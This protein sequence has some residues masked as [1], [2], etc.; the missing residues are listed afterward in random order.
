ME[1]VGRLLIVLRLGGDSLVDSLVDGDVAALPGF[2]DGAADVGGA[3][4]VPHVVLDEPEEGVAEDVVVALVDGAG[5]DN[6]ADVDLV[7]RD[8]EETS[9]G[10]LG[11]AAVAVG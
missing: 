8:L 10:L 1:Y 11:G 6:K 7:V 2:V 9:V 5:H 4:G 3:R